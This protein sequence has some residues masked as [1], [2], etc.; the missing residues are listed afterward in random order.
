MRRSISLRRI[1]QKVQSD[2]RPKIKW[3]HRFT[4]SL[5]ILCRAHAEF[6]NMH[7]VHMCT[8][9]VLVRRLIKIR[10]TEWANNDCMR[11]VILIAIYTWAIFSRNKSTNCLRGAMHMHQ[12]TK[13]CWRFRT[14]NLL[15]SSQWIIPQ[16]S[17]KADILMSLRAHF[18]GTR[19]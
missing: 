9:T 15:Y 13:Y 14:R 4:Y 10:Q 17:I 19:R 18:K 7:V 11:V 8:F 2:N 1:L 3:E 6:D 12:K 5:I 16:A